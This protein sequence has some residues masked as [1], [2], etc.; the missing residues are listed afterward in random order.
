MKYKL[1]EGVDM[2]ERQRFWL[3]LTVVLAVLFFISYLT[4][5][6]LLTEIIKLNWL[7]VNGM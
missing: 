1:K 4:N 3:T 2:N 7:I 6:W 5:F